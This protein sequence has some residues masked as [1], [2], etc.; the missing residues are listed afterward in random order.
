[1]WLFTPLPTTTRLMTD[2]TS[3]ASTTALV[4]AAD[5]DRFA[6]LDSLALTVTGQQIF[7]DHAVL[8]KYSGH[9]QGGTTN[10][11]PASQ[12]QTSRLKTHSQYSLGIDTSDQRDLVRTQ[13]DT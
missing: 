10:A 4:T 2:A 7:P 6:R 11:N 3:T 12:S 1:M 9:N 5:L 13:P 8:F